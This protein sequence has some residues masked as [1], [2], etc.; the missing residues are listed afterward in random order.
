MYQTLDK[1]TQR[2]IKFEV[3]I[4]INSTILKYFTTLLSIIDR[5]TRYNVKKGIEDLNSTIN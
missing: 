3:K 2:E 4:K 1:I 5:A